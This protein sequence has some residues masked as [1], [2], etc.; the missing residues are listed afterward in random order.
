MK[1]FGTAKE[2]HMFGNERGKWP[3]HLLI[4]NSWGSLV[5]DIA[6]VSATEVFAHDVG[7][8]LSTVE[9]PAGFGGEFGLVR[10]R[11]V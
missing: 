6:D 3:A 2:G 5:E 10:A 9:E 1:A 11:W 8:A 7:L 4:R